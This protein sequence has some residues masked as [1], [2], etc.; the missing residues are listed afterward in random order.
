MEF[1]TFVYR[2]PGPH[3]GPAIGSVGT[4]YGTRDVFDEND[5]EAALADGWHMSLI[6]AAEFVVELRKAP[7]KPETPVPAADAPP[8]REEMLEQAE[9]LSIKVDKRW[10]DDTLL[11]KINA[12]M[13]SVNLV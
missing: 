10:G 11:A 13:N 12:V 8:T 6:A 5:L 9:K 7:V 4:T 3:A 2:C 1:P